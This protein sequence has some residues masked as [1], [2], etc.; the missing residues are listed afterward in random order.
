MS[1]DVTVAAAGITSRAILMTIGDARPAA[2]QNTSYCDT[3]A[4]SLSILGGIQRWRPTRSYRL[5]GIPQSRRPLG[6]LLYPPSAKSISDR[7]VNKL[8]WDSLSKEIYFSAKKQELSALKKISH[9]Q[10]LFITEK[11]DRL[12]YRYLTAYL[13]AIL[14]PT[15]CD[16]DM[17]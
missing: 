15:A 4:V 2:D 5:L 3:M 13:L 14:L 8:N 16:I 7:F 6:R 11:S 1:F 10:N 12:F 17:K 9:L